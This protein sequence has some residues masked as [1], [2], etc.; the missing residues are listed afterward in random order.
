ME[1]NESKP[2]ILIVDDEPT[3]IKMLAN[4]LKGNYRL[5]YARSGFRALEHAFSANRPDLVLLD[6]LM[7]EIDGY[8]VC[9]RLKSDPRT[10]DIPVIFITSMSDE[11]DETRGFNVGAA[12][13]ITKPIS[14]SKVR[15]RV[16]TH[17]ELMSHRTKLEDLLSDRTAEL[18]R[19]NEK[20]KKEIEERMRLEEL[21][22]LNQERL[23]QADKMIALGVLVS[24]VAHEINNPNNFIMINAPILQDAWGGITP[25]LDRYY[26]DAGDFM[27]AGIPY[28]EMR[29][30]VPEL[31][32]GIIEGSERIM[33][34]VKNLKDFARQETSGKTS[35]VNLNEV[36][37]STLKLLSNQ[38]EK[39][40]RRFNKDMAEEL[41]GI[42]GNFQRI[43]QVFVN[44]IINACQALPSP[45][46]G[47]SISTYFDS[48]QGTSVVEV[49]DEGVGITPE[50]L[51]QIFDPFFTT[52]R[53]C[54]GT[55]LGLSV[56][57][58][59]VEDHCGELVF[60]STPG[61][62]T[63]ARVAFPAIQNDERDQRS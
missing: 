34:I 7:P 41:P 40:T 17:L 63:K 57:A 60:T 59:I 14:P 44:L 5:I 4:A 13:Y 18:V 10:R 62:G 26:K 55:G 9:T 8:E 35:P 32:S 22:R 12:D 39:S 29:G 2:V 19:A 54:G 56:C 50:N 53:D 52:R 49:E 1:K 16:L 28:S 27:M 36:M 25:I 33:G 30:G 46:K 3:N 48:I 42:M 47:I 45:D 58:G 43:E 38:I 31:F 24:G 11:A 23:I 51:K 21:A 6:I 61:C 20:L 15:A 37:V